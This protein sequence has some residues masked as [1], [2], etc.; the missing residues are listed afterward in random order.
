M[1]TYSTQQYYNLPN[2][3]NNFETT[4][5][6]LLV[7]CCGIATISARGAKKVT[8]VMRRDY[9]LIYMICGE[10]QA[11]LGGEAF[12]LKSG[13][14]IC[15]PPRTAYLY[16]CVSAENVKYF[17]IH[18]TGSEAKS[19]LLSSGIAP[20]THYSAGRMSKTAEIYEQIFGEFRN[21]TEHF[22][23]RV[24]LLLRNVIM[25]LSDNREG[26]EGG[27]NTLDSSLKYVHTHINEELTVKKLA[28]MEYLS[29]GYYRVLFKKIT[30][31]S[32]S[33][34]IATQRINRACQLLSETTQSIDKVAESVGIRDRLY[35]QRFFK[36][37]TG[38]TP[39]KYR[40]K[41]QSI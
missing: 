29:E 19:M 8:T 41:N 28:E 15:I 36:K 25:A 27:K 31:D 34:Y 39:S 24:A 5:S 12:L 35:F 38:I 9:Y 37:H 18:F 17:W 21:R 2:D 13:S 11:R 26:D 20:L 40:E 33:E 30:G 32:P 16:N 23:Y 6:P 7:N 4:D 1:S 3:N 22:V 10:L 14:F